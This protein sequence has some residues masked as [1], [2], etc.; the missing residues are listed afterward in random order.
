MPKSKRQPKSAG[1]V[2]FTIDERVETAVITN[3]GGLIPYGDLLKLTGFVRGGDRAMPD[4]PKTGWHHAEI[5][6]TL[7]ALN[8]T[9]GDTVDDTAKLGEDPGFALYLDRITAALGRDGHQFANGGDRP[10]PSRTVIRDWLDRCHDPATTDLRKP[11]AWIPAPHVALTALHAAHAQWLTAAWRL[12]Q[13]PGR[14]PITRATLEPD[15]TFIETQK[16]AALG[17]YKG[18]DAYSPLTVRWAETGFLVWSEFRDGNVPPAWR[19]REA[20][21]ESLTTVNRLGITD[22]WV[23][24]DAAACQMEVLKLLATW[25]VDDRPCPVRFAI[26]YVKTE[27]FREAVRALPETD[28]MP[29]YD[30]KGRLDH[31]VAEVVFVSNEEALIDARP[32]RHLVVRRHT[33][34]GMLPGVEVAQP[35]QSGDESMALGD[36]AYR[37]FAVISNIADWT[38]QE[39]VDWYS[40]RC[41]GGEAIQSITKS[42]LAGG[43]LPSGKFGANAAWWAIVV[44]AW[45]VHALLRLLALPPE[46]RDRRFKA[47]RYHFITIPARLITHARQCVVRYLT[48]TAVTLIQ[49]MRVA[50][51]VLTPV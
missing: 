27:A 19:N 30:A 5:L 9:G 16:R 34:Q 13:Q 17:C 32:F 22:V 4:S 45:N 24:S 26:G 38:P 46:L 15:A 28:W 51:R 2:R 48:R 7:F 50:L 35:H 8:W 49:G 12:A 21:A 43:Q 3:Y 47:L 23:R 14:P 25:T 31:E 37:I 6:A 10:V 33:V 36:H 42:D 44:W 1:D 11:G 40:A 39:I 18:F 41:G 29:V 20:L